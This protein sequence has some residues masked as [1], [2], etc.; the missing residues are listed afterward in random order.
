MVY[1]EVCPHRTRLPWP[2]WSPPG[3]SCP[4]PNLSWSERLPAAV[5]QKPSFA[6]EKQGNFIDIA[7]FKHYSQKYVFSFFLKIANAGDLSMLYPSSPCL[8]SDMCHTMWPALAD[9]TKC[10]I[11]HKLVRPV[12]AE[13]LWSGSE[14]GTRTLVVA[15]MIHTTQWKHRLN[16]NLILN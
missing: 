10:Q 1:E 14:W 8:V 7:P 5:E 4:N 3:P 6:L 2:W 11:I 9:L 12:H 15:Y 16:K 13:V